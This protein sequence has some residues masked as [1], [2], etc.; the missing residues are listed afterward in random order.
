MR[1][2]VRI[3][4]FYWLKGSIKVKNICWNAALIV[5]SVFI[6]KILV[7]GDAVSAASK[8]LQSS[9]HGLIGL[10]YD[11]ARPRVLKNSWQPFENPAANDLAFVARAMYD[12]GYVEVGAC[13]P[14]GDA[15]CK[16][17][18]HEP[19]GR[20]LEVLTTGEIPHVAQANI[21]TAEEFDEIR[22]LLWGE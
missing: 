21:L 3:S 13:S 10:P 22:A 19:A 11:K 8:D 16:F 6:F 17:Y 2:G 7:A 1:N 4:R 9:A 12:E 14:V 15:P 20:Y 18:F 5:A